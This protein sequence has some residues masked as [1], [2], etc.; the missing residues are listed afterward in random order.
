MNHC[1]FIRF[2][3]DS[4]A[5]NLNPLLRF[6]SVHFGIDTVAGSVCQNLEGLIESIRVFSARAF[7][8]CVRFPL[9]DHSPKQV[10]SSRVYPYFATESDRSQIGGLPDGNK[11]ESVHNL[12][13]LSCEKNGSRNIGK[14]EPE[15]L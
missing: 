5:L 11:F 12:G 9:L 14:R 10:L 4:L 7:F 1:A 3:I 2:G 13:N 6:L 8:L 15:A